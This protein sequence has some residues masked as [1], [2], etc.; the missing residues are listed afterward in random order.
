MISSIQNI[1][2]ACNMNVFMPSER[3]HHIQITTQLFQAVQDIHETENGYEFIFPLASGSKILTS[4]AE[5]IF[6]ERQCCPFLK[7]TLTI[8]TDPHPISLILS[9]PAGT[10]EFLREEFSEVF[11]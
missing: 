7:F 1:P 2:I 4:L 8:E 10:Q 9:G 6:N 11:A 5:F 3:E